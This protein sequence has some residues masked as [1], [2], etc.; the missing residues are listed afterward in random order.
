MMKWKSNARTQRSSAYASLC[1]VFLCLFLCRLGTLLT[2]DRRSH[3]QRFM[4]KAKTP[5]DADESK[6]DPHR[7]HSRFSDDD[8]GSDAGGEEAIAK[9]GYRNSFKKEA[10]DANKDD[11]GLVS[12]GDS[13]DNIFGEGMADYD[14]ARSDDSDGDSDPFEDLS[15]RGACAVSCGFVF[16]TRTAIDGVPG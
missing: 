3:D 8:N 5:A 16:S 1:F 6:D 14:A 2:S 13:D 7:I 9:T 15:V 11:T 4:L 12:E 10:T